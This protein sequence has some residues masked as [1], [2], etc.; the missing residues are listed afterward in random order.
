MVLRRLS[1]SLYELEHL[2]LT[3]CGDWSEALFSS[4]GHDSVDWVGDWGKITTVL[5]HP[6]Y[7]LAEAAGVAEIAK[8]RDLVQ[9]AER[10]ERHIT[11][12]RAGRGRFITVETIAGMGRDPVL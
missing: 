12:K 7:R 2:D 8:Y 11:A 4:S 3:G 10:V 9:S 5:L 1:K 6:G